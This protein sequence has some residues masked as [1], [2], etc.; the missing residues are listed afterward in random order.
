MFFLLD[1]TTSADY[2]R[3]IGHTVVSLPDEY[4]FMKLDGTKL[5]SLN[6]L[7]VKT[8]RKFMYTFIFINYFQFKYLVYR[9]QTK[10]NYFSLDI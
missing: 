2:C 1:Q 3:G 7:K 8:F 4:P 5:F 9:I 6:E 10:L